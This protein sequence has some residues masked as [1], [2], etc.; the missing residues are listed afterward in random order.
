[1]LLLSYFV[2]QKRYP[3]RYD[4]RSALT[5]S[6]LAAACYCAAMLPDINSI[7]LKMLYRTAVLAVYCFVAVK[8]LRFNVVIVN[9]E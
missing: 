5:Y 9:S 6:L 7:T 2:G 1:M 4:L 3:I 8:N